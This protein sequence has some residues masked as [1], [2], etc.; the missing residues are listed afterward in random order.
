MYMQNVQGDLS[1]WDTYIRGGEQNK[2]FEF[3][4]PHLI[5]LVPHSFFNLGPISAIFVIKNLENL[6]FGTNFIFFIVDQFFVVPK[7]SCD[8]QYESLSNYIS[9]DVRQYLK[10]SDDIWHY[11]T[12][13]NNISP[14]LTI[15]NNIWLYLKVSEISENLT[16]Y[17]N[18][19]NNWQY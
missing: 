1:F 3:W 16:T 7:L 9:N 6:E 8:W 17:I 12:M 10:I 2:I 15:S 5:L 18:V 11:M 4:A 13:S 19:R 14:Y